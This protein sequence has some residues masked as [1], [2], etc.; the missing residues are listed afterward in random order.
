MKQCQKS[1]RINVAE[2]INNGASTSASGSVENM[3]EDDEV[4]S[5]AT[6]KETNDTKI[7]WIAINCVRSSIIKKRWAAAS[8]RFN[9]TFANN[10]FGHK[11][12]VCDRLWFLHQQQVTAG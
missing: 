8:V 12:D 4:A 10:P 9:T 3:Q 1:K 6:T 2:P 5:T 7:N 11:C